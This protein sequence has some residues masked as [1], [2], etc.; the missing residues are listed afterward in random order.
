MQGKVVVVTGASS[1]IG[2]A[3]ALLFA[4]RGSTVIAVGRNEK[5]L[6][7]LGVGKN[8]NGTLTP[9][10]T[11]VTEISQFC[12]SDQERLDRNNDSRRLG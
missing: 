12:R 3:A 1:G 5:E 8:F 11:D 9:H 4:E 6:G 2:R 7:T 10:L